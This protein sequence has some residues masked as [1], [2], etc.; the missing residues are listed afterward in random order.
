MRYYILFPED[1]FNSLRNPNNLI[2]ETSYTKFYA[3]NGFRAL[4]NIISKHPEVLSDIIIVDDNMQKYS[5]EQF[6]DAIRSLT[7]MIN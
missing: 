2:G 4:R 3:E 7:L 5:V 6:L 1:D